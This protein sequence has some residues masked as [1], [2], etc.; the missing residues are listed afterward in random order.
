MENIYLQQLKQLVIDFLKDEDVS[1]ILFGSMARKDNYLASDVD[2][3]LI[4]YG[5]FN[6]KKLILLKEKI[7]ES[8]IPY[9]VEIIDFSK[10]SE[11]FKK[12]ALKDTIVWKG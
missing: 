2:I 5:K 3:G 12:V 4:P 11:E 7:E 6:E 10:V 1:V 8:N 9:K